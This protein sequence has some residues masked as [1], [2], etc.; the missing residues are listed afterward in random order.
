MEF[1]KVVTMNRDVQMEL[2]KTTPSILCEDPV[3]ISFFHTSLLPFLIY[4]QVS[5]A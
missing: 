5:K 2:V 3:F 1:A 4:G